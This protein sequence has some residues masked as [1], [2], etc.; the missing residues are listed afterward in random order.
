MTYAAS[1]ITIIQDR[2]NHLEEILRH[3]DDG[4]K[5]S[6]VKEIEVLEEVLNL[7]TTVPE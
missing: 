7:L 5:D 6:V 2:V 4:N 1:M 3:Y